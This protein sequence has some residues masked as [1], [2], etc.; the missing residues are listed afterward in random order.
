[1]SITTTIA[2]SGMTCGHCVSAVTAEIYRLIASPTLPAIPLL[3]ACGYVLAESHASQRLVRFFRALFGWMPGGVA[4][5][6]LMGLDC[7]ASLMG[8]DCPGCTSTLCMP[9][10]EYDARRVEEAD[11]L[12]K[13]TVAG[14]PSNATQD[15]A[16]ATEAG[17][18]PTPLMATTVKV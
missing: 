1:M 11:G 7:A 3:T 12:A 8:G 18:G 2:V 16:E 6:D 15:E 14:G 13:I 4:V 10:Y 5:L 9:D 17:P